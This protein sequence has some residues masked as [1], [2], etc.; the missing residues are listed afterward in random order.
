MAVHSDILARLY[1]RHY[2][3]ALLY[4]LSLCR[5]RPLAEDLV[6]E[7]F[8]RAYLDLPDDIP[9]FPYWLMRVLRNLLIDHHR[10]QKFQS[11]GEV[12]EQWDTETPEDSLLRRED[13]R[14]LYRGINALEVGDRELLSL[15]YFAQLPLGE[16]ARLL[17]VSAAAAKTRLYRARQRLAQRM[18]EDHYE[19]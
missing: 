16:I 3:G 13:I 2:P 1:Q 7:A 9:S 12:P 14:A 5:N 8:I 11:D 17:N 4:A 6:Q 10:R 18:K 19:F 15:F